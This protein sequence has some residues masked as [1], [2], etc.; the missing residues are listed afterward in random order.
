VNLSRPLRIGTRGSPLALAQANLVA[1]AL[2]AVHGLDEAAVEIVAIR[3][4]GDRIQ[5]RP[6]ADLG[7]KALWTKELDRALCEG[8]TDLSVHSMKDVESVRP[9]RLR[10]AG[11]LPRADVRDRL[12]GA[13][14]VDE[15]GLRG[16]VGTS[17]P[18]RAAQLR[19]MRPDLRIV[20]IR[21]NV[22]T[23]LGK[24]RAGECDATL[25]AAAGL[26]RLGHG[27]IGAAVPVEVMLPA[28]AQGAIG[29]EVRSED[30]AVGAMVSAIAHKATSE[31]IATERAVL[32]A[33]GGN[34]HAPAAVL[35]EVNGERVRVRA[36]ILSEDGAECAEVDM[37]LAAGDRDGARR[38][39]AELLGRASP[40][41]RRHFAGA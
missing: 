17:S 18:R 2:R 32:A 12:I 1:G 40:A 38:L 33:L 7:G 34:C 20:P 30:E 24:L 29:V 35:A 9:E 8:E 21:G 3:T 36:Q 39:A 37:A 14:S 27:E 28:A 16:R 6:L 23:R 10:L 25:L 4:T 15:I 13:A 5:D 26:D 31:A 19:R 41:I 11:V 22:A